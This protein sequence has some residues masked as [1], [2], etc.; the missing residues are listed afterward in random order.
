MKGILSDRGFTLIEVLASLSIISLM[1]GP[2]LGAFA[3]AKKFDAYNEQ[4]EAAYN[5][6]VEFIER[7]VMTKKFNNTIISPVAL[8][9]P[10]ENYTITVIQTPLPPNLKAVEVRVAWSNPFGHPQEERL[11]VFRANYN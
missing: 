2:I 5:L 1:V 4:K 9:S 7:E 11:K 10:F 6:L 8:S 3:V